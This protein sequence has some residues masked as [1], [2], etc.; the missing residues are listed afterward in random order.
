LEA[1]NGEKKERIREKKNDHLEIGD[2]AMYLMR[3]CTHYEVKTDA[4]I[5]CVSL[6]SRFD[7]KML[8]G[9]IHAQIG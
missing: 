8:V 7:G 2:C 1:Y 4:K 6:S 5:T 3:I 9:K